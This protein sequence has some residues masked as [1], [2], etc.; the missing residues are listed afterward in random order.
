MARPW[1]HKADH[2]PWM[3]EKHQDFGTTRQHVPEYH[4]RRWRTI[5][6]VYLREHPLCVM[7]FDRGRAVPAKICDHIKPIDTTKDFWEQST[8]NNLQGLCRRC[9]QQ[10]TNK[11]IAYRRKSGTTR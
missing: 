4:T 1:Q 5:R 11:E 7:C 6:A 9:H 3:K 10:K 8:P 2:R